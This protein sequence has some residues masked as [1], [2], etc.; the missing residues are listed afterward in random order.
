MGLF[1]TKIQIKGASGV[2]ATIDAM[3]GRLVKEIENA[4]Q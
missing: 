1:K 3:N 2:I 4:V